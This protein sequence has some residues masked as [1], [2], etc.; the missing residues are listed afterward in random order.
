MDDFS[1]CVCKIVFFLYKLCVRESMKMKKKIKKIFSFS[2]ASF[3]Y[4][5][6]KL[7]KIEIKK[8][9]MNLLHKN[10]FLLYIS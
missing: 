6:E 2:T 4:E 10:T 5:L 7:L 1:I 8:C 3:L 9:T